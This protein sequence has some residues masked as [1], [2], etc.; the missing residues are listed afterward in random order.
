MELRFLKRPSKSLEVYARLKVARSIVMT[1]YREAAPLNGANAYGSSLMNPFSFSDEELL[2]HV[3]PG[4]AYTHR[5]RYLHATTSRSP[6]LQIAGLLNDTDSGGLAELPTFF[7]AGE[8]TS[9]ARPHAVCSEAHS[10]S[11]CLPGNP[12]RLPSAAYSAGLPLSQDVTEAHLFDFEHTESRDGLEDPADHRE[13]NRVAQ[14]KFRAR[15]KV[16][17]W[18]F[19][20][21]VLRRSERQ[22]RYYL[23][24]VL[25][26]RFT[27][28]DKDSSLGYSAAHHRTPLEFWLLLALSNKEHAAICIVIESA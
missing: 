16:R 7:D 12:P 5:D 13:K 11:T 9:A 24:C 21:R 26:T 27:H 14:K 1:H 15:Q 4:Q 3:T 25:S 17:T 2:Q 23:W 18:S 10:R 6:T 8:A 20:C 19:C 28:M 22:V